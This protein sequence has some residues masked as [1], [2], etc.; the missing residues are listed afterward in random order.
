MIDTGVEVNVILESQVP[1]KIRC[2]PKTRIQLQLYD[3]ILIPPQ[4]KFTAYVLWKK[5]KNESMWIDVDD[6]NLPGISINLISCY[7]AKW[8]GYKHIQYTNP[9]HYQCHVFFVFVNIE[10]LQSN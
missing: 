2:I 8:T 7:L 5:R 1:N 4:D 3:S 9:D 10:G 6:N